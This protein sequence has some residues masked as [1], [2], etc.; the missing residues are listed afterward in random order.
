VEQAMERRWF[1][2]RS[3]GRTGSA[4]VLEKH[5]AECIFPAA[6]PDGDAGLFAA[7][8]PHAP[9]SWQSPA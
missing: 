4:S 7:A 2:E 5:P 9:S 6:E 1:F 8:V 3:S